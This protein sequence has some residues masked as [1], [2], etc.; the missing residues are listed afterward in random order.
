MWA[1]R[2]LSGIEVFP[3]F[4]YA[5]TDPALDEIVAW[6]SRPLEPIYLLVFLALVGK[7]R[8]EGVVRNKAIDMTLGVRPDGKEILASD[9]RPSPPNRPTCGHFEVRYSLNPSRAL[10]LLGCGICCCF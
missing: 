6:Q 9:G 8:D 2:E 7:I 3:K 1:R 10:H 5:V 4:G